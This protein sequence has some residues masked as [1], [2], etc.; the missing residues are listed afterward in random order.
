MNIYSLSTIGFT[1]GVSLVSVLAFAK[2]NDR[3]AWRFL[4]FS[5]GGGGWAFFFSIWITQLYSVSTSVLLM[6]LSHLFGIFIPITWI[7]FVFEFL[8]KKEPFRYFYAVNYG[9]AALLAII[10][11]FSPMFISGAQPIMDFKIYTTP[12]PLYHLYTILFFTIVPLGS[13]Y[14]CKAYFQTPPGEIRQSIK[15]LT[16]GT[17]FGFSS[18]GCAFIPVYSISFPLWALVLLPTYPYL[19]GVALIR[20]GLFDVRQ[21]ADAFQREKM[22]VLGTMAASLNH[23]LRNPLYAAKGRIEVYKEAVTNHQFKTT[24]QAHEFS[25]QVIETAFTQLSRALDIMQRFSDFARPSNHKTPKEK[26]VLDDLIKDSFELV[27]SEFES[28]NIRFN[29]A[30]NGFS[31]LAN[32]RQMEEIFSNLMMNGCQAMERGGEL[33]IQAK[34]ANSKIAIEVK[35]TGPG[36][37]EE[38]LVRIFEPFF[39]TKAEK[40]TGLGLYIT[41]QLVERNDGQISVKSKLGLGSCF[42]MEF[43]Q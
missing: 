27:S 40:G 31:F 5:I 41:K 39:T 30:A 23:E 20:Y 1:F 9:I 35:D 2:R 17:L 26:I 12:G 15:F 33:S 3:I 7:H 19:I 13:Y 43:L 36:I 4:F 34:Q 22:A 18:G 6:R 28:R 14:L 37:P 8:N 38:N 10:G 25:E 32:R 42:K 24:E 21:I 29:Y 11:L 16:L